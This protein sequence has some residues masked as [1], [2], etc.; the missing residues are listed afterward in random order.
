MFHP[1]EF[2]THQL[3]LEKGRET[4]LPTS[5]TAAF[6]FKNGTQFFHQ[7]A[8]NG[9]FLYV[10]RSLFDVGVEYGLSVRAR[11]DLGETVSDM[12]LLSINSIVI[13][14]TPNHYGH[15][16]FW[17]NEL[18]QGVVLLEDLKPLSRYEVQ[19]KACSIGE[20]PKCS[21]WSPP[22]QY[23]S[24]GTAPSRKLDVWRILKGIQEDRM[25]TV[26]VL[27][28]PLPADDFRGVLLGYDLEYQ[29]RGRTQVVTYPANA[30]ERTLRVSPD[31]SRI[32]VRAI[33]SAGTSP[34]AEL[35][36]AQTVGLPAPSMRDVVAMGEGS[37]LLT[38]DAYRHREEAA[39][40]YVLQ[41][42]SRAHD[43]QWKRLAAENFSTH[44]EGLEPGVRFNISLYA[45]VSMGTSIPATCQAYS[46]EE[47]PLSGP[48]PLLQKIEATRIFIEW[49]EL[50]L[51]QRRGFIK[52]YTIYMRKHSTEQRLMRAGS[53]S[54]QMWLDDL[55]DAFDLHISA[56]NSAGEGPLGE[57]VFCQLQGSPK[58]GS[59]TQL[60]LVIV[61]PLVFLANLMWWDCVQR[62]IKRTCT[63]FGP[64]WLF[65]EFPNVDNSTAT[66]LLQ[67]K[68]RN[69]SDSSWR[70]VYE[71]PPITPVED[72]P[73]EG[74][75][76]HP[77]TRV[78]ERA[79]VGAG[80]T[81]S[82]MEAEMGAILEEEHAYRP[83]IA[84][85]EDVDYT[86]EEDNPWGFP[87][88]PGDAV[89]PEDAAYS[90]HTSGLLR[91]WLCDVNQDSGCLHFKGPSQTLLAVRSWQT[92]GLA[93][94][95]NG[96]EDLHLGQTLLPDHLLGCLRG[97]VTEPPPS[98]SYFPEGIMLHVAQNNG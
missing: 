71:D 85:A 88:H 27:W 94:P 91:N 49:E 95:S 40:G 98:T 38:W 57:G 13:P 23:T 86:E 47:R 69:N 80:G 72:V 7:R 63:T 65:E 77:D 81:P 75:D 4:H 44:I 60:V 22:V 12:I 32:A 39:S 16:E 64:Y 28:K 51:D 2:C 6:Q 61:V 35:L 76:W 8:H 46:R 18:S 37:V 50:R 17:G 53:M 82:P 21:Q 83:Q 10:P 5:Y 96:P 3:R 36:I 41:W 56:S 78:E 73:A 92:E 66:Q 42:Q 62:R 97:A 19:I 87:P 14:S 43:M 24:P 29:E 84:T 67:E 26:T 25:R 1:E 45:V 59:S 54:R 79:G 31:V 68:E 89:I 48:K 58:D 34:P 93:G 20:K 70:S 52:S 15:T 33:T 74:T 30:T 11:N 55:D 90:P 9:S